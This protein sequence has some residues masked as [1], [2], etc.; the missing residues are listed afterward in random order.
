MQNR[1]WRAGLLLAMALL[2]WGSA[3]YVLR[4]HLL[5]G[6]ARQPINVRWAPGTDEAARQTAEAALHLGAG[7]ERA[8]STWSYR[9]QDH[10]RDTLRLIVT[11]PLVADTF[12]INR[13]AFR[14]VIDAPDRPLWL[15]RLLQLDLGP[16]C[17]LT[18]A[19]IGLVAIGLA[20][21]ELA[22]GVAVIRGLAGVEP[23]IALTLLCLGFGLVLFY[24]IG[25]GVDENIHFDQ[26][27]RLAKG[28]WSL[29]SA[30]TM[31]P[32]FHAL[33]AALVWAGGGATEVSV[34]VVVFLLS[35]AT[36]MVFHAL[37]RVLRPEQAGTRTLQF[38]LLPILFPQFFLIYT[39]VTSLLIVLLMFAATVRR[40]DRLAG[41]LGLLSCLVRQDNVIWV[42]FAVC[43]SYLRDQGW[44]W[45]PLSQSLTRYWTFIATGVAFL[46]FVVANGSQVALGYDAASHPLG[47]VHFTNV[48]FL[49]FLSCFLFLPLWWGYRH[50]VLAL[51]RHRRTWL[52]LPVLLA[53]FWVGFVNDH[54]HNNERD[55]Y[56]LSNAILMLFSSAARL[57]LLFFVPVAIAALCMAAVPMPKPWRLLFPFTMLF[58]LPEWLVVPRYYLIP[59]SLFLLAREP[60]TMWSERMQTT[61]FLTGS[62]GLF[63]IM[64][65][66]WGW[67]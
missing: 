16:V 25:Q 54:P 67:L 62:T 42:A 30:L 17:A 52:L 46:L 66:G 14:I 11:H 10:S 5:I 37:A 6:P 7:E 64:E 18:A 53:F 23:A 27:A 48:F 60:V 39:D 31:V 51:L 63:L 38:T 43:W 19:A 61:L 3:I 2:S 47:A 57:K 33:V 40:H 8:P 12:H 21:R 1:A 56:F 9:L 50:D 44:R 36:I 15:R 34:R 35:A 49:L 24:D 13:Q 65:W 55:D 58:L 22:F 59:L 28:G 32:G 20:R 4:L 41:I 29:N 45:A 26:I